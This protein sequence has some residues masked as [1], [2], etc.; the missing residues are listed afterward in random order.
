MLNMNSL[1][2]PPEEVNLLY[3]PITSFPT[4]GV[5][6]FSEDLENVVIVKETKKYCINVGFP[7]GKGE[8]IKELDRRENLYETAIRELK[9]ESGIEFNKLKIIKNFWL[10]DKSNKGNASTAYLVGIHASYQDQVFTYDTT[11]LTFSGWINVK[12]ALNILRDGRKKILLDAQIKLNDLNTEYV[13]GNDIIQ[14]INSLQTMEKEA[15]L[16]KSKFVDLSKN[17]AYILRH[18]F[19]ELKL[20]IDDEGYIKL[21]DILALP[22]IKS[23]KYTFEMIE[24]VVNNNDKKRYEL[25]QIDGVYYI[26]AN[27]GHSKKFEDIINEDKL[28][29]LI[30]EPLSI[31]IHGTTKK[32]W[33]IIKD[34]GLKVMGR[35]H[36]HFAQNEDNSKVISGMRQ[37]SEVVIYIDMKLAMEDNIK[38]YMS[39]NGVVL[40][41]GIDGV[42]S[43]KYFKEVFFR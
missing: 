29:S 32:A 31:C 24:E 28:L 23:K 25:K 12:E 4:C 16:K 43:N 5:V 27:Q 34:D 42:L 1:D 14:H 21:D 39:K 33:E 26:R 22:S 6:V 37:S 35:T 40:T 7:K 9:E 19:D 2:M 15:K 3:I 10:E 17:L 41:K 38:F 36:I 11:E 18:G 13:N 20:T 30:N 8:R